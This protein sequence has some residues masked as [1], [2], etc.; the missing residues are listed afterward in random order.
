MA[1]RVTVQFPMRAV[2][3]HNRLP[4]DIWPNRAAVGS[5]RAYSSN[6]EYYQTSIEGDHRDRLC[7]MVPRFLLRNVRFM[8]LL[9]HDKGR[10]RSPP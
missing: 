5:S 9:R 7:L 10:D 2:F 1:A 4:H 8:A 6:K 3:D